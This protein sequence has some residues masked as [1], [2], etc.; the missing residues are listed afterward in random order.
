MSPG[1]RI[2]E[3]RAS[4]ASRSGERVVLAWSG[5]LDSTVLLDLLRTHGLDVHAV[6]VDHQMRAS[7]GRD[8]AFCARQ[9]RTWGVPLTIERLR[10]RGPGSSQERARL[11]RYSALARCANASGSQVVMTAHHGEDALETALLNRERGAGLVGVTSLMRENKRGPVPSWPESLTLDR[12]LLGLLRRDIELYARERELAWVDD[13]TNATRDYRRNAIRHELMPELLA[14]GQHTPAWL[15]SLRDLTEIAASR[16]RA[17]DELIARSALIPLDADTHVMHLEALAHAAPEVRALALLRFTRRAHCAL[18]TQHVDTLVDAIGGGASTRIAIPGGRATLD[19]GLLIVE[20]ARARGGRDLDQRVAPTRDLDLTHPGV[21][22]WFDTTLSVHALPDA[23][24]L[25][26]AIHAA[27]C[28]LTGGARRLGP[29]EDNRPIPG[30]MRWRWPVIGVGDAEWTLGGEPIYARRPDGA[31][32]AIDWTYGSGSAWRRVVRGPA[33]H[34][35]ATIPDDENRG[36]G[37]P[38]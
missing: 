17:A 21:T 27:S 35:R 31:Y 24:P 4:L 19:H 28:R 6:H 2:D 26:P 8:A 1:D 37:M 5:G 18:R 20:R 22:R 32:V 3:V 15:A 11:Q 38:P 23:P 12:P 29:H 13:P 16:A 10:V 7:S 9:A 14:D 30:P 34:P 36:A 25:Q 33:T